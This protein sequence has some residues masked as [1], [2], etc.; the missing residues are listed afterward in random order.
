MDTA[1]TGKR[2]PTVTDYRWNRVVDRATFQRLY[3]SELR[4]VPKFNMASMPD[5]LFVLGKICAD[6][7]VADLRWAAYMLATVFIETSHTIKIT[8][9]TTNKDGKVVTHTLKQWRNFTPREE[10]GHGKGRR[11]EHP[12]KVKRLKSGDA[13]ITEWD[14]DQWTVTGAT[15][16]PKQIPSDPKDHRTR[17]EIFGVD[18]GTRQSSVYAND[19]GEPH[20]Y[21]G[22]GYVQL[23]HWSGYAAAGV[24]LGRGLAFLLDPR[25]VLD[26]ELSY[27]I[28]AKGLMVGNIFSGSRTL[29]SCTHAANFDYVQA[30]GLVNPRAG[31]EEKVGFA[32]IAQRFENVLV[33]SRLAPAIATQ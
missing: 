19:D 18:P 11:Y 16:V 22:R 17:R 33:A 25:L 3:E 5:L 29:A 13:R 10:T 21:Y 20:Y 14:G 26:C 9:Q 32:K 8:K 7:R 1:V 27:Q 24:A 12:V 6:A 31:Q 23:T 28:M 4:A 30:R 15:G 2:T